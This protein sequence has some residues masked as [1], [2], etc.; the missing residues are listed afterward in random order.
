MATSEYARFEVVSVPFPFTD[1]SQSKK[2][3]ALVL[4]N[5]EFNSQSGHVVL[6]MITSAKNSAW[7][8]DIR[9]ANLETAGL[10]A[11]SVIRLKLFTL[12]KRLIIQK[13]GQ[14]DDT[15]IK[16]TRKAIKHL[17]SDQA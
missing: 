9:I 8:S 4:S 13:L 12:D 17:F 7:I 1:S 14:L 2:R 6:A 16:N 15:D 10:P 3:P 11:P 5:P